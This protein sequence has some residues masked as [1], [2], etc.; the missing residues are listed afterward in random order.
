MESEPEQINPQQGAGE[1]QKMASTTDQDN[2][3][4]ASPANPSTLDIADTGVGDSKAA[5]AAEEVARKKAQLKKDVSM[6]TIL[7]PRPQLRR[8][9]SSVP[10]PQQPLPAPGPPPEQPPS[11][12][13]DS[14]SLLQLKR[15]ITDMPR[16]EPTAYAFKYDDADSFSQELE[17]WF[18]YTDQQRA[19]L[20]KTREAFE[21]KWRELIKGELDGDI[22]GA[23]W[24]DVG[25]A[26]RKK[27][28]EREVAGLKDPGFRERAASLEALLYVAL[29]VW[30]ET[31]RP[32]SDQAD[33]MDSQPTQNAPSSQADWILSN[34]RL[35]QECRG[36][37]AV[38]DVLRR[39]CLQ[40]W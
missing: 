2:T 39:S 5:E 34:T 20:T 16:W 27:F 9:V 4:G 40:E 13:T 19:T 6:T 1:P 38:Y 12:A 21:L 24:I 32:K 36:I 17:E 29:G 8:N 18:S 22:E 15:L 33:E 14:L 31:A 3:S 25:V 23:G 30:G 35:I 11:G 10:A 28:V 26:A 7:L 37:Q